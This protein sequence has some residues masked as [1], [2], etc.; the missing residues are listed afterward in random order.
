MQQSPLIP[1]RRVTIVRAPTPSTSTEGHCWNKNC[2]LTIRVL[3]GQGGSDACAMAAQ[4]ISTLDG[5][6]HAPLMTI[7]TKPYAGCTC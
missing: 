3:G 6:M 5:F 1:F 7:V 4:S 2:L